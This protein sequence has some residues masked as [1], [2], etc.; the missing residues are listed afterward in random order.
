MR[1]PRT[2][3]QRPHKPKSQEDSSG[4][5][6]FNVVDQSY[7]RGQSFHRAA[8]ILVNS[9]EGGSAPCIVA[10]ALAIILLYRKAAEFYLKAVILGQG[11]NFLAEKPALGKFLGPRSPKVMVGMT[12]R[13]LEALGWDGTKNLRKVIGELEGFYLSTR[14]LRPNDDQQALSAAIPEFAKQVDAVLDVLDGAADTL[15]AMGDRS[16]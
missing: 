7:L 8:K 15:A 2:P 1:T 4:S 11:G 12:C 13:I 5:E 10:D 16:G 6:R 14:T 9:L 3:S